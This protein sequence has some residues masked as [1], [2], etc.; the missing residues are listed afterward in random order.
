MSNLYQVTGDRAE[1]ITFAVRNLFLFFDVYIIHDIP[2]F[3]ISV[4][5]VILSSV[6][7]DSL[8]RV[9]LSRDLS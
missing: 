3:P 8:S 1:C 9:S 7:R 2:S 5:S 6:I 4:L